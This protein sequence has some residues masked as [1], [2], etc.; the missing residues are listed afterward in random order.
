MKK[1]PDPPVTILKAQ[2]YYKLEKTEFEHYQDIR[3]KSEYRDVLISVDFLHREMDKI[4]SRL[5]YVQGE[6]QRLKKGGKPIGDSASSEMKGLRVL[7]RNLLFLKEEFSHIASNG[8]TSHKTVR[9][10]Q[11]TQ[12]ESK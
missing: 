11:S 12:G 3:T 9:S 1:K 6:L 4:L 5:E 10:I 7:E 8:I 2:P